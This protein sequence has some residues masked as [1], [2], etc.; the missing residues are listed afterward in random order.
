MLSFNMQASSVF[1]RFKGVFTWANNEHQSLL[2]TGEKSAQ[3]ENALFQLK[4]TKKGCQFW[5]PFFS[6]NLEKRISYLMT[7]EVAPAG[8]MFTLF[9]VSVSGNRPAPMDFSIRPR[10]G[11]FTS[12]IAAWVPAS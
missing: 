4:N 5:H 7:V 10:L 3:I 8:L 9:I 6:Q 11:S 12:F 2:G 1:I